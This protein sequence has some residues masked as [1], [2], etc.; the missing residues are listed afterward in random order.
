MDEEFCII[1]SKSAGNLYGQVAREP[2][3]VEYN[4]VVSVKNLSTGEIVTLRR[5][6]TYNGAM[7]F[8]NRLFAEA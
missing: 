3:L 4:Y 5:Y 8:F 2:M 7:R 1:A 6:K